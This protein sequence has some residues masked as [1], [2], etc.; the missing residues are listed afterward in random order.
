LENIGLRYDDFHK[1]IDCMDCQIYIGST[2]DE[3]K[4]HFYYA[5]HCSS[6]KRNSDKWNVLSQLL[7]NMNLKNPKTFPPPTIDLLQQFQHVP[8]LHGFQCKICENNGQAYFC[9]QRNSLN[10]HLRRTHDFNDRTSWVEC[11]VQKPFGGQKSVFYG[12]I[13]LDH[14]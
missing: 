4:K 5:R 2:L 9:K 3:I 8:L 12:I 13:P 1:L 11:L 14:L 10:D 6:Y 7:S